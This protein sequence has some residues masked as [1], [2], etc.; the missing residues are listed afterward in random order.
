MLRYVNLLRR[1]LEARLFNRR[2]QDALKRHLQAI[3]DTGAVLMRLF[4]TLPHVGTITTRVYEP[5][6]DR[7]IMS[8]EVMRMSPAGPRPL[9]DR[10]WLGQLGLRFHIIDD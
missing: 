1:S 9:S 8:G 10:M 4:A 5:S 2:I 3:Q 6:S 7:V